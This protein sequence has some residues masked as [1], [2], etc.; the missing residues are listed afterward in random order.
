M[1]PVATAFILTG[2]AVAVLA[3][4]GL[5]RFPSPYAR[6]HAAGKASPVS[7]V[8]VAVGAGIETGTAGAVRLMVATAAM[9]VTLPVSMHL[10]FRAVHRS[11]P[12]DRV[13]HDD[14]AAAHTPSPPHE[15]Q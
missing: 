12:L 15:P 13:L 2:A 4:I 8:L 10:L 14:L 3:G 5:V 9:I 6:F 1:N 11:S 7:F